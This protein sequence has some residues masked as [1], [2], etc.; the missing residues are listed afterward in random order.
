MAR[1]GRRAT[2]GGRSRSPRR[3]RRRRRL[4]R[5]R[6]LVLPARGRRDAA[7]ARRGADEPR[8]GPPRSA[9]HRST[10]TPRAKLRVFARQGPDDVAVV[11]RGFGAVPGRGA[12]DRVLRRRPAAGRAADPRRAQPRERRRRDRR[13]ARGRRCPTRRSP[14]RSN[15]PG[16]RAPHRGGRDRRR[17][18]LRQR[19]E[20]DERRRGAARA[21]VVSRAGA[22]T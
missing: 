5:V 9:R 1:R 7:A 12:P 17:R 19:L 3:R 20:G 21:R 16:C 18:P 4:D 6:A 15:V 22:S 11:P 10:R 13:R 8:A 14:T 2:S